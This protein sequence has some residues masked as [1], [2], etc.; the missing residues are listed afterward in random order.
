MPR[1][2]LA[3]GEWSRQLGISSVRGEAD[4]VVLGPRLAVA[5]S[6]AVLPRRLARILGMPALTR[7]AGA[8]AG[9]VGFCPAFG[10]WPAARLTVRCRCWWRRGAD[11]VGLLLADCGWLAALWVGGWWLGGWL[12]SQR[13]GKADQGCS[14][15][16]QHSDTS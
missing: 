14:L 5:P 6:L 11:G 7:T 13:A 16:L 15:L 4:L 1:A 8:A 10:V 12:S 9:T 3:R 2:I